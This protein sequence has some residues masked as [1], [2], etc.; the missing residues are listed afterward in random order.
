MS[1][2]GQSKD[3]NDG[4]NGY[5]VER[6]LDSALKGIESWYRSPLLRMFHRPTTKTTQRPHFSL[7]PGPLQATEAHDC[8]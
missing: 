6:N 7:P 2:N 1:W 5:W 4:M 8:A 3:N